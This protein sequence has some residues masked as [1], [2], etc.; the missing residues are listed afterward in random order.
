MEVVN[1]V[2]PVEVLY[3]RREVP[4]A[5][6]SETVGADEEQKDWLL[7]PVGADTWLTVTVTASRSVLS[8]SPMVWLA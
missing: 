6:K 1:A 3:H 5:D 4:V 8:Q 7:L 2:P